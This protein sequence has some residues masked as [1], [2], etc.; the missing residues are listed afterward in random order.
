MLTGSDQVKVGPSR[1]QMAET[2]CSFVILHTTM[3]ADAVLTGS[4]EVSDLRE[5]AKQLLKVTS[6]VNSPYHHYESSPTIPPA[7]AVR[8]L[9]WI[10]VPTRPASRA[11]GLLW[12]HPYARPD[13]RCEVP[14]APLA[15]QVTTTTRGWCKNEI[16]LTR[17]TL[18]KLASFGVHKTLRVV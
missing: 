8:A 15:R 18:L 17:D 5:D 3:T 7:F 12:R 4:S 11:S 16:L 10:Y 6:A 14:S 1:R 2:Y 13:V 9:A